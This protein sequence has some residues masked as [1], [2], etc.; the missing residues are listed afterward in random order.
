MHILYACAK[1][2]QRKSME[3]PGKNPIKI[4]SIRLFSL[5]SIS[6]DF[7][8]IIYLFLVSLDYVFVNDYEQ[9]D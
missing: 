3:N 9:R 6:I 1:R 2:T 7:N 4:L 5:F 8:F